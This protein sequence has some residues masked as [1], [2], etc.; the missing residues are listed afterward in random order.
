MY[1]FTIPKEQLSDLWRLREFAARGPIARQIR[2]AIR[3]YL[4]E[5]KTK[6]GCPLI[7]LEEVIEKHR[8][9]ESRV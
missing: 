8:E 1:N 7:E 5:Q 2:E 4:E 9:E 6:I 3:N